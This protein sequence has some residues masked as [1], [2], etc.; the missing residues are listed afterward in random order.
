MSK[1]NVYSR[2]NRLTPD[3]MIDLHNSM[4][5]QSVTRD[6]NVTFGSIN[7][8]NNAIIT[9]NLTVE[10]STTT[11]S[12]NTVEF[13]D[14]ILMINNGELGT[15]VALGVA[16][17][18]IDRGTSP[19]YQFVF[20]ESSN[21]FKI[22][23]IGDLQTV[24]TRQS[25]PLANGV[26][27]YNSSDTSLDSVSDVTIDFVFSSGTNSTSS[28][29]G[30]LRV[31]G[32]LGISDDVCIDGGLFIKGVTYTNNIYSDNSDNLILRA[33]ANVELFLDAGT[34]L[35]IPENVKASFGSVLQSV[36]NVADSLYIAAE[37]DL[38][39]QPGHSVTI[40]SNILLSLGDSTNNFVYDGSNLTVNSNSDFVLNTGVICNVTTDATSSVSGGS[41]TV[42]GGMAIAKNAFIGQGLTFDF[43]NQGYSF[44]G[45]GS[46]GCLNI[47]GLTGSMST[48]LCV[49]SNDGN[50]TDNVAINLYGLG[51]SSANANSEYLSVGFGSSNTQYKIITGSTGTG[52]ARD[53][54]LQSSTNTDQLKLLASGDVTVANNLTTGS[55]TTSTISAGVQTVNITTVNNVNVSG[56][57]SALNSKVMTNGVEKFLSVI[58][59]ASP[60]SMLTTTSFE[61]SLPD[62]SGTFTTAY[63]II[64]N[65]KGYH[66]DTRFIDLSNCTAYAIPST[67]RCKIKFTS[68]ASTDPHTLQVI[69]RYNV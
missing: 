22:G 2:D 32:G 36:Y 9:G 8:T 41:I 40:P 39:L 53:L 46:T 49:Y 11:V 42:K 54:I 43:A 65:C 62:I 31:T 6:S 16:G 24:A 30:A 10:G 33:G 7:I 38:L 26:M 47:Q 14:N 68:G 66:D 59:R 69:I 27:I 60:S 61:F 37:T 29:T 21:Q 25:S 3:G 50:N 67:N 58:F 5:D 18:E 51:N 52:V 1:L 55:L 63:D 20:E 35:S 12:S 45:S 44:T 48:E 34:R 4:L 19:N 17:I 28:S 64:P 13:S 57:V 15:G 23:E 56:S